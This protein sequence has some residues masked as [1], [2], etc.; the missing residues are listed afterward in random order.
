MGSPPVAIWPV[1]FIALVGD[2]A[3]ATTKVSFTPFFKFWDK[4][5]DLRL[6]KDKDQNDNCCRG[7][8]HGLTR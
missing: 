7:K 2:T 1:F 3:V 4:V 8:S 6:L 5:T